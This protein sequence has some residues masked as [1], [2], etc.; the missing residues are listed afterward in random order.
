MDALNTALPLMDLMMEGLKSVFDGRDPD[1]IP[2]PTALVHVAAA[3]EQIGW[4]HILRGR[5]S[6]L[7]AQTQQDHLGA[8]DPRKNGQTW[9]TDIIQLLLEG[10]LALW[11]QR[12]E[13]R[14]GK[15]RATR[16]QIEKAQAIRELQQLYD[17]KDGVPA[18]HKW[19]FDTPLLA[20]MNMTTHQ[21]RA[22]INT[23]KPILIG[24]YNERQATG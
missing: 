23:W 5:L 8:F 18:R 9:A 13:D 16:V 2:V 21:I 3:Q 11:K 19:L 22:Y 4:E 6:K 12:N 7:W 15:D 20:R 1:T 17:L 10:W 14:H 24:S